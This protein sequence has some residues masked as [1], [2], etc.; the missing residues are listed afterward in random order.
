MRLQ[1]RRYFLG[2]FAFGAVGMLAITS[3]KKDVARC[4]YCGM[5]LDMTSA[6]RTELVMKSGETREFDTPHCALAFRLG[7]KDDVK[8]VRVQDFYDRQWHD[9]AD[10]RFVTGSDVAGPMGPDLVPV[11]TARV[12]KFTKDHAASRALEL[13]AITAD[14]LSSL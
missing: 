9:A 14:V 5:K 6:W 4:S 7:A 12:P 8:T 1:D 13:D 11:D 2:Y 10:V 3:C